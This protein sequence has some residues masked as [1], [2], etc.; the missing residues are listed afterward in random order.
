MPLFIPPEYVFKQCVVGISSNLRVWIMSIS[1][2][3][4]VFIRLLCFESILISHVYHVQRLDS[5]IN[6][7]KHRI[8]S[9]PL[10]TKEKGAKNYREYD[11]EKWTNIRN[12]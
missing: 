6:R 7:Y 11:D 2:F 3:D 9:Q 1:A 8:D 5:D 4:R 12:S 10:N